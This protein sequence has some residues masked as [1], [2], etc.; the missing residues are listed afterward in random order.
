MFIA[1]SSGIRSDRYKKW[2]AF[3]SFTGASTPP[4]ARL[5]RSSSIA[6]VLIAISESN[7]VIPRRDPEFGKNWPFIVSTRATHGSDR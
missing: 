5:G 3:D 1:V 7:V 2:R 6:A 4:G